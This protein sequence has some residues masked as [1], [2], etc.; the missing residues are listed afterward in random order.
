MKYRKY[1]S[2]LCFVFLLSLLVG[3]NMPGTPGSRMTGLEV[4]EETFRSEVVIDDFNIRSWKLK[5]IYSDG[6]FTYVNFSYSMLSQEDISKLVKVGKHTLTFNHKGFS[7]QFE[8]TINNPSSDDI[9]EYIDKVASGLT[10]PTKTKE[11]FSL[12]TFKDNVSI[13]WTSNREEITINKNKAVVKNETENDVVVRL[14]ATLTYYNESKE[15]E[16]EVIVPGVEHVH[17]FVE[18]ECSC[19]EKDPNYVEHTHV[20]INGKCTCGEVDPNYTEENLNVPYTG[21]YYDSSNLELD[22]RA[23]LL[24]LRKL[25]TDTHTKVV[26]YGE[27]RYLLDDTDG[28]ESDE[29]KVQGI[30]SQVLVSGVWDGGN[31]WNREHVWPQSLSW[32]DNTNNSTRSAG[33]DLHH[34]RPEDPNV[35]STR[36]NCKFAEFDGGKEVKTSKGA[37]TGCYR[38]G[39]LFEPQDSAKGDTARI[40]FYLFVRYTEADKYD[41]TDV[42]ESLEML[43]EWNRLDPVDEWEMERNDETAKIQGNR[44]PFIDHPEFADIIWGE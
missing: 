4:D 8:I 23:L 18:G 12:V 27:A 40:L 15:F 2:L 13:E 41:F 5:E 7:C 16:F 3:C 1:F 21:T 43:L 10:V 30:Y 9:I 37:A 19:G 17:V 44:N 20:F 22:D 36:N 39:D 33:S 24:E 25:I 29:S 28:A 14:T 38:L 26:S 11:D 34:I 35:N 42:A 6:G 32:F 31:S